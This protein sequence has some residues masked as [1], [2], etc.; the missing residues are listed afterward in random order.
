MDEANNI[1]EYV[2]DSA[3]SESVIINKIWLSYSVKSC[4]TKTCGQRSV[5]GPT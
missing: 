2:L 1:L 5:Y 3:E 4:S